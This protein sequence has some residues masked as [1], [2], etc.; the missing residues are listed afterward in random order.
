ME[1][2]RRGGVT[3]F[4]ELTHAIRLA[5]R[6]FLPNSSSAPLT[7]LFTSRSFAPFATY[8]LR[9]AA[10]FAACCFLYFDRADIRI[11]LYQ[12]LSRTA[13]RTGF[14]FAYET[15]ASHIVFEF[16]ILGFAVHARF[17]LLGN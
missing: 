5:T 12:H 2:L 8:F 16:V 1:P 14:A 11:I 13:Q 7:S 3:E 6:S 17:H 9:S 15:P 4:G 10:Y